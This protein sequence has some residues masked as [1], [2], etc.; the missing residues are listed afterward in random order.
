[1]KK[2]TKTLCSMHYDWLRRME[3]RMIS[4]WP[5]LEIHQVPNHI[6]SLTAVYENGLQDTSM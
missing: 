5:M 2:E 1:M 6:N 4:K 3:L